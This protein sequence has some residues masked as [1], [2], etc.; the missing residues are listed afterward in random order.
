MFASHCFY[1][2]KNK[3]EETVMVEIL[4]SIDDILDAYEESLSADQY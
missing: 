2:Y 4:E 1:I 3:K